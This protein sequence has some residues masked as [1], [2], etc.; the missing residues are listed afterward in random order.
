MTYLLKVDFPSG[1]PFG[2]EM[3]KIF[4]DLAKS[5]NKDKGFH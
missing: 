2:E 1:C 5:I 4:W 3:E